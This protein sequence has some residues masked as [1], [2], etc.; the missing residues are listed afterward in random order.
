[1]YVNFVVCVMI[2]D[3]VDAAEGALHPALTWDGWLTS[4]SGFG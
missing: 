2:S 4:N 3:V 1:M